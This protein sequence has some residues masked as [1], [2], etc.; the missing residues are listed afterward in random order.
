[1]G[2]D[3]RR[4][5]VAVSAI[6]PERAWFFF[7]GDLADGSRVQSVRQLPRAQSS[8]AAPGL[9]PHFTYNMSQKTP[10]QVQSANTVSAESLLLLR[11]LPLLEIR[12]LRFV[13]T[14]TD[15]AGG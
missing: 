9:P 15:A 8:R 6:A 14:P 1:M 3:E 4:R 13:A 12:I 10:S 7:V 11:L 5:A 2:G